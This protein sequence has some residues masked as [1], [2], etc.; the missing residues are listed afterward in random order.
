MMEVFPYD[1]ILNYKLILLPTIVSY[2]DNF[3]NKIVFLVVLFYFFLSKISAKLVN[4]N[5]Y[6]SIYLW[7]SIVVG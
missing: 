2:L 6:V 7:F 3:L 1:H 4:A 5:L